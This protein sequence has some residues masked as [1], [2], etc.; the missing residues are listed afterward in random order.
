MNPLQQTGGP[1]ASVAARWA[2]LSGREQGLL[3]T[4]GVVVFAAVLWSAAIAPAWKTW[5]QAPD[6]LAAARAQWDQV[7]AHAAQAKQLRGASGTG[8]PAATP[9]SDPR[10]G[11]AAALDPGTR[12]TVVQFL[13]AGAR[14]L[15]VERGVTL[16]FEGATPEGLR[17]AMRTLRL[18]LKARLVEAEIESVSAGLKGRLRLEWSDA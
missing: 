8:S 11:G 15:T 9:V 4:A 14:V 1:M 5:R 18:R 10:G 3:A 7:Q 6:R 13:G 16:E 17:E 2:A 12:E